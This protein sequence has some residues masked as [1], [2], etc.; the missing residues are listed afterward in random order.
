MTQTDLA[1]KLHITRQALSS[2]ERGNI[3]PNIGTLCKLADIF[4]ITIDELVGR[5]IN[6]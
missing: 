3:E 4:N 6:H 5:N 2:Y 1:E